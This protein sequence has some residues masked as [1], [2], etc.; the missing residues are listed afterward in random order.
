MFLQKT[1]F[2]PVKSSL[3]SPGWLDVSFFGWVSLCRKCPNHKKM[4]VDCPIVITSIEV[5][6]FSRPDQ[7][8]AKP[9]FCIVDTGSCFFSVHL[10]LCNFCVSGILFFFLSSLGFCWKVKSTFRH[11]NFVVVDNFRKSL[12]VLH[13]PGC[14]QTMLHKASEKSKMEQITNWKGSTLPNLRNWKFKENN[15]ERNITSLSIYRSNKQQL[16]PL[17]F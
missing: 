6:P 2:S 3:G 4:V 12:S 11:H 13:F 17:H 5:I 14:L 10:G 9:V 8:W 1:A 15:E 7:E 16:Y